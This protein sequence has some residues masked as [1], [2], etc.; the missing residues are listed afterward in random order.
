MQ[1]IYTHSQKRTALAAAA[2]AS[3][4]TPFM[5]SSLAVAL[6]AISS[7]FKSDIVLSSWTMAAFILGAAMFLLP[8]G[9]L[10]EIYG[11][12]RIFVS[13]CF[14]SSLI[15]VFCAL[16][17]N[18]PLFLLFRFMHGAASACIFS[19][20]A[21]MLSEIYPPKERGKAFGVNAAS[22]YLGGSAG[23]FIGGLLT[24]YITWRSIFAISAFFALIVAFV[25]PRIIKDEWKT[26]ENEKLDFASSALYSFSLLFFICGL[27]YIT[28]KFGVISFIAGSFG[29]ALFV[30]S[31][32]KREYSLLPIYL[33]KKNKSFFMGNIAALINYS[34]TA[35]TALL[36]S[37]YLQYIK[38]LDADSSGLILMSQPIC[39]AV[40]SPLMGRLS[41]RIE[42]RL[43]ASAGMI[44]ISA[45]LIY[46]SFLKE[47]APLFSIMITLIVM[48]LGFALFSSPNTNAVMNSVENRYFGAANVSLSLMRLTGQMFSIA[49]ANIVFALIIGHIQ[50]TAEVHIL[51][52]QSL[53]YCFIIFAVLCLF[54]AFAS[55]K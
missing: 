35:A 44:V 9:K 29:L 5:G 34:A 17:P 20:G 13:G 4:I 46:F 33:F 49:I 32:K 26:A 24:H 53:R 30:L 37:Y 40:L 31:Q 28:L 10:A 12:K 47:S 3:F 27:S 41:D 48:G 43:L 54:G 42:P 7:E 39:M 25:F 11:R 2:F 55:K 1:K 6:P 23:P 51:L 52:M 36:M 38:G 22:I 50:V 21:A 45:A 16:T 19:T 15:S 18:M 14:L 8:L